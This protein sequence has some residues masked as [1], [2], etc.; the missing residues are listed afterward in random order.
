M[1]LPSEILELI[2]SQGLD[3]CQTSIS[4][5]Q[6][7]PIFQKLV[8]E[9]LG[10][11]VLQD[12]VQDLQDMDLPFDYKR[13]MSNSNVLQ[14]P[15]DYP[16]AEQILRFIKKYMHLLIVIQSDRNYSDVLASLIVS[17]TKGCNRSTTV[18]VIYFNSQNYLSKLYFRG[19][20]SCQENVDF[21]ELHVVGKAPLSRSE[22]FDVY[23]LFQRTFLYHLKNIYS[24]DIQSKD[25]RVI[26]QDLT[27]INQL[28]FGTFDDQWE[29]YFIECPNLRKIENT[30]YPIR[31]SDEPFKLPKCESISLTHYVDGIHYQPID[32][33]QIYGELKLVPTLR[34]GDP[35]FYNLRFANLKKLKLVLSDSGSH[36]IR[37]HD[38][39]FGSVD[40]LDCASGLV[41]WTDLTDSGARLKHMKLSLTTDEQAQWLCECPYRLETIS[42]AS[43]G[44]WSPVSPNISH[45][46]K[47]VIKCQAIDLEIQSIWHLL[48][49]S[50]PSATYCRIHY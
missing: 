18:S 50:C 30:K 37:F 9:L 21:S 7:S 31:T 5:M 39:D 49:V 29:N 47:E 24:L 22:L 42:I 15:T 38:C 2:V 36:S 25:H 16:N 45:L 28:N 26:S 13:L 23:T 19:M 43:Y 41:P 12:G 48:S 17:I 27:V 20:A 3:S 4:W 34:S 14:V 11:V 35:E 8:I 6:I 44:A 10:V 46:P 32:G 40:S 1:E 33:S